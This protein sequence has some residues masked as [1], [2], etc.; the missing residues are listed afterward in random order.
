VVVPC[1]L[2]LVYVRWF[3]PRRRPSVVGVVSKGALLERIR[4]DRQPIW[5]VGSAAEAMRADL[6]ALA[7]VTVAEASANRPSAEWVAR[8]A[9]ETFRRDE[10]YTLEPAYAD[11]AVRGA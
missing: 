5:V 1:R 4:A 7:G 8:L 6:E 3:A 2:D 9:E 11:A 10:L